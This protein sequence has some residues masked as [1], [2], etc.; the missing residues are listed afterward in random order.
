MSRLLVSQFRPHG[1]TYGHLHGL[2][3]RHSAALP[4]D[5]PSS[6]ARPQTTFVAAI[7]MVVFFFG[8]AQAAPDKSV[9]PTP[10]ATNAAADLSNPLLILEKAGQA[11]PLPTGNAPGQ[12]DGAQPRTDLTASLSILLLLTVLSIA[13]SLLVLTTSFTRIVIVLSLLRQAM[14]TQSL[15][16]SQ[17]V[18]GLALF[19]TFMVMGPTFERIHRQAI[20]PLQANE[21]DQ[22]TAWKRA[23]GPLREFMFDQIE[24]AGNWPDVYLMLNYQ[25]VDTSE[26]ENLKRADV[27]M[28]ALIPAFVLS[29]LKVS[30]LMAFRLYLPFLVID[31]VV[32]SVMVSM[33]M[34]M[35]PPVMISL[36]FKLLMFV[37]VDGW[38]LVVGGLLNSFAGA[39]PGAGPG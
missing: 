14:G 6:G 11:L 12:N 39:G 30:F 26:P 19:M 38:H 31:L 29:E 16:P 3:S 27:N 24:H 37:L 35:L 20:V 15:P 9:G 34:M 1:G 5:K 22:M 4:P 8:V 32:A 33:G 7:V 18:V 36:P 2:T 23:T 28:L 25:G 17:V 10:T 21:I 13:P